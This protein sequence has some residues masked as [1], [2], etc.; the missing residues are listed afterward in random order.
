MRRQVLRVLV[1]SLMAFLVVGVG[2][3]ALAA[4]VDLTCPFALTVNFTPGL[5]LVGQSQHITGVATAGTSVSALTPCS[6]VVT[7][8]PYTGGTG[9]VS[10]TG[11]LACVSVGLG[12]LTGSANGTVAATWNN[13]DTSTFT[14][15]VSVGGAVPIINAS[16]TGGALQGA[17]LSFVP[18]LTGLTGNCLLAPV[19]T[20]TFAG[21]V[22]FSRL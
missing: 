11:T 10:G 3:E 20:L 7:G 5:G 14:W 22:V 1:A 18:T 21:I 13:G 19:T 15:S 17:T 12:G 4:P 6:S 8:V 9:Q 16:V 2:D